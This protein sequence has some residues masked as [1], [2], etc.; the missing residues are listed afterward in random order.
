MKI[1]KFISGLLVGLGLTL[2][3]AAAS[4]Q[5]ADEEPARYHMILVSG[6]TQAYVYDAV[7]GKYRMVAYTK[8]KK[9]NNI[10]T[11]LEE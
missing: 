1:S 6:A 5:A 2:I 3:I 10:K 8:V 11:L 7:T 9:G 4:K